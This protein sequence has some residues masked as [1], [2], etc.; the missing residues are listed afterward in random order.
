MRKAFFLSVVPALLSLLACG[1]SAPEPG[2]ADSAAG[3]PAPGLAPD[4]GKNNASDAGKGAAKDAGKV[5]KPSASPDA[6]EPEVVDQGGGADAPGS[7]GDKKLPCDVQAIVDQYCASCHAA[8]PQF[9]A[10][11]PLTRYDDFHSDAPRA[12]T[13]NHVAAADRIQ[14]TGPGA[15]PPSPQPP[16]PDDAKATL[17][18]WLDA[19]A[20][21][22]EDKSQCAPPSSATPDAGTEP[23]E[24]DEAS[25][26]DC[27]VGFELRAYN[28][29]GEKFPIPPEDDHYECFYFKAEVDA[30]TLATSMT[31][32]LDDTRV[33]HHWL[34]FAADNEDE[35]PSGTHARCDG[36][37]PGAYLMAAWLPGTPALVMP[38]DV[39]ME[40]PSGPKAQ[41]ILENHYNNTARYQGA[42]DNSGVRVC[43]TNKPKSQ[44]AAI[45]WLGSETI[46]LAPNSV[47][48]TEATCTP[49]S[50]EPINIMGV[51][52]HMHKLGRHVTM[53]VM[54]KDGST[55]SLHDATFEFENQTYYPKSLVLQPGDRVRTKCEYMNDTRSVVT[56]GESTTSEMCYMFTLAY[57]VGSMNT[58]G[59]YRNP[60]TGAPF[61][62]GPNR[63]ML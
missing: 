56:L 52:P 51:I 28:G 19:G 39:G 44:H 62:Q 41:F 10:P 57:P 43:A 50:K 34:L 31:P 24:S 63:C 59:N 15:M 13:P 3:K 42:S 7:T 45:H 2:P 4:A 54:R 1:E 18:A 32:L 5:T 22:G 29:T 60:F 23:G 55:E 6:G 47:G 26:D 11:M 12:K 46:T 36:I 37:H 27:E 33:L 9:G 14:R 40:M 25:A 49:S 61:V 48:S 17:L 58:G 30:E 16:L 53:T 35:A 20:P 21:A 38:K 8:E